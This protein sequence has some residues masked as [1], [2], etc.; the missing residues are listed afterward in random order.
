M[1]GSL[2][3]DST[4]RGLL[5]ALVELENGPTGTTVIYED[6]SKLP[7]HNPDLT[8]STLVLAFRQRLASVDAVLIASP[9][10]TGA[11]Q[12]AFDHMDGSAK[13]TAVITS[14]KD[15]AV[16]V[17]A[18]ARA[19]L[20]L[21]PM[22]LGCRFLCPE[23]QVLPNAGAFS[24][25]GDVVDE[26]L[27]AK[28]S[29]VLHGLKAWTA[30]LSPSHEVPQDAVEPPPPADRD[31]QETQDAVDYLTALEQAATLDT[32]GVGATESPQASE[33]VL[34]GGDRDAHGCIA[35]AGYTWCDSKQLCLRS[36][37]E[38]CPLEGSS[39][40]D[41]EGHP[42]RT[43]SG[44]VPE[45]SSDQVQGGQEAL[46]SDAQVAVDDA[47]AGKETAVLDSASEVA[48]PS[49]ESLSTQSP[50]AEVGSTDPNPGCKNI[51]P[52]CVVWA[53]AGECEANVN[54][55]EEACPRACGL[56]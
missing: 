48:V 31:A 55:M 42:R 8:D 38:E 5:R 46:G 28:L 17:G 14:G 18:A 34:L 26:P 36:W 4:N 11:L 16:V 54:Y 45:S 3:K 33:P 21:C 7:L 6:L 37:E 19:S 49:T 24:E 27:R 35:S 1:C 53:K 51:T 47:L 56:C 52:D 12:N 10:V 13:P 2:R 50:P 39:S 30:I 29:A 43:Q 32:E 15:M 25:E 23:V 44:V 20:V 41:D 22:S 40:R 9:K